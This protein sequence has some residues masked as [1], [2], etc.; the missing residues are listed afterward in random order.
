[1]LWYYLSIYQLIPYYLSNQ[2]RL[3]WVNLGSV[4]VCLLEY[5]FIFITI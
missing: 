2:V 4:K 5:V 1:M 3:V